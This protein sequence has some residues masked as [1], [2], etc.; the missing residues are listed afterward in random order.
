M[1]I[2]FFAIYVVSSWG[3]DTSLDKWAREE[4]IHTGFKAPEPA[5]DLQD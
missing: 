1:A 5:A 2:C 3:P 4:A